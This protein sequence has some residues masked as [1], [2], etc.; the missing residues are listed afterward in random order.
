MADTLWTMFTNDFKA[1]LFILQ[2]RSTDIDNKQAGHYDYVPVLKDHVKL[3][4]LPLLYFT[5]I[6][7]IGVTILFFRL[8]YY[9]ADNL[10]TT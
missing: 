3:L 4:D 8:T 7:I 9:F 1:T 2:S 6:F 5:Y 10:F